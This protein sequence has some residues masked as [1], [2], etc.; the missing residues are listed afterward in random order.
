MGESQREHSRF[1]FIFASGTMFSRILG[2]VRD[3]VWALYIPTASRD[4]FLLAFKFP[5]MLRDLIGEGAVNAAF[6]PVFSEYHETK[7]QDEYRQ[8]VASAMTIMLLLLAVLTLVG[9]ILV[10]AL[11][12]GLNAL[13]PITGADPLS[14]DMLEL[15]ATLSRWVFPYLFL[16][17]MT[18]FCMAPLFTV[19]HYVTPSWS[20]ALLNVSIIIVCVA[21][22]R[23]FPDPSYAVL[24]GVW[25]GGVAQLVVNYVALGRH[26]GVWRP[27]LRIHAGVR[28]VFLLLVP[29]LF[30]Q[31]AGEVNK[32]VDALFA[33]SLGNGTV[34]ALY[35]ANRLVQLPLSVFGIATAVAILPTIS[36]AGARGA[37]DE[38]RTTLMDGFRQSYFLAFPAMLGLILLRDPI[39]RIFEFRNFDPADAARTSTALLFYGAGLVC[40]AGVKVA[41]SGFYAIQDTRTPVLVASASMLLNV[42][43][44]FI[45]VRPL[46]YVGLALATTISFTFNFVFLYIL[47]SQRYGKLWDGD[48][49]FGIAKTTVAT[50]IM[51]GVTA[52]VMVQLNYHLDTLSVVGRVAGVVIPMVT[53]VIAYFGLCA[54]IRVP[55]FEN[56]WHAL[57]RRGGRA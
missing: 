11:V 10:P 28:Q 31:A 42:A 45:L 51:V 36:R 46:E 7:S 33:A 25:V 43:V 4:A 13:R 37:H 17:G 18:V 49:L 19:K 14:P 23:R 32:L 52:G 9:I 44:N 55:E 24:L 48:F 16:I 6:I 12:Q 30:G 56:M 39:I 40:F 2:F 57:R 21:F 34:T 50:I 15:M 41:V 3:F 26:T 22:H 20:P 27:T 47:L 38:I 8:L 53:A 29:V 1:T 54:A 35:Y 5:N